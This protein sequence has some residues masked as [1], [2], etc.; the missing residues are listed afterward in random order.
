[1]ELRTRH[2]LVVIAEEPHGHAFEFLQPRSL[3]SS[4][5][6]K[7]LLCNTIVQGCWNRSDGKC[8]P[9]ARRKSTILPLKFQNVIQHVFK[10]MQISAVLFVTKRFNGISAFQMRELRELVMDGEAWCVAAHGAAKSWRG[11]SD[12]TELKAPV[13]SILPAELTPWSPE[14]PF[15]LIQHLTLQTRNSYPH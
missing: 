5:E 13:P 8:H 9:L 2:Y 4:P 15:V 10:Q 12:Q 11:L 14:A 7:Y 1:M 6:S 3:F